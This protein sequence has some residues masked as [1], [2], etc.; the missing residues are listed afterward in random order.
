MATE[1]TLQSTDAG[2][3]SMDAGCAR[4][5]IYWT[6]KPQRR[7]LLFDIEAFNRFPRS[8]R[9]RPRAIPAP[10]SK[11]ILILSAWTL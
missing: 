1:A 4:G 10:S 5:S 3:S 6:E 11:S 8:R 9:G 7:G 2:P